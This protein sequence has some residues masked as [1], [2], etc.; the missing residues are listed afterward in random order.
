MPFR[1]RWR[2][3][4][5]LTTD[6]PLHVGD[7]EI[8][9]R[10]PK[11]EYENLWPKGGE[12]V[13]I[14]SVF[15]DACGRAC[16]PGSTLKGTVK[17]WLEG[18]GGLTASERR[19]LKSV[20][21]FQDQAGDG[22]RESEGGQAEFHDARAADVPANWNPGRFWSR[23]RLT[24]VATSVAI[25]RWRRTASEKK[26]FYVEFVPEGVTFRVRITGSMDEE[27]V[28]LLLLGLAGFNER[29]NGARVTLGAA[30][31][32]GWG[33]LGWSPGNLH[34]LRAEDVRASVGTWLA[35]PGGM[36]IG[37]ELARAVPA[38]K[39]AV[40]ARVG[41]RL[42]S[43]GAEQPVVRLDLCLQCDGP[44]LVNDTSQTGKGEEL[45]DHAPLRRTRDSRAL[46]PASSMRGALRSQAERIV[47]TVAG[48]DH[49]AW[50]PHE[51]LALDSADPKFLEKLCPVSVIFGA[52]GWRSPLKV[53]DFVSDQV[54]AAV[55][56]LPTQNFL[57]IDRF[58]GGGAEH[59]KFDARYCDR[60]TLRGSLELDLG[61]VAEA[62]GGSW[63]LAL[64]ALMFRDL[65]EGDI[66]LGFG[67]AKGYGACRVSEFG[68]AGPGWEALPEPFQRDWSEGEYALAMDGG[69]ENENLQ[70]AV[71]CWFD[72]L[73]ELS[74]EH[75]RKREETK[76]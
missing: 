29:G 24:C 64:L 37:Y 55:N 15:T 43:T 41:N 6:S 22:P 69:F 20:L 2:I 35:S 48:S 49:A 36:P 19:R 71:M 7:G 9:V 1:D 53:S 38:E 60:P 72:E 5:T 33:R 34:R 46:L 16:I 76:A 12:P 52:P 14:G 21:G 18:H 4:G 3:E 42:R 30:T 25:D 68:L 51:V 32:D 65:A 73:R 59:L 11:E 17:A 67:A 45:P 27:D 63:C 50:F 66:P 31:A 39:Q 13:E 26:L 70:L 75:A 58:T 23:Q 40:L 44:F 57:A 62:G 8:T 74:M 28:E 56:E 10:R 47:R 61:A 54:L